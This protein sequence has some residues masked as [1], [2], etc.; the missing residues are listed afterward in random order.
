MQGH[1]GSSAVGHCTG[2]TSCM[3][4]VSQQV[5]SSQ[6][7]SSSTEVV[8]S[9]ANSPKILYMGQQTSM[10][11]CRLVRGVL[12]ELEEGRGSHHS[13]GPPESSALH[14]GAMPARSSPATTPSH[15]ASSYC[16]LETLNMQ[17]DAAPDVLSVACQYSPALAYVA[18]FVSPSLSSPQPHAVCPAASERHAPAWWQPFLH[19]RL[20]ATVS[21]SRIEGLPSHHSTLPPPAAQRHH[22]HC[23]APNTAS[24]AYRMDR[25]PGKAC[26]APLQQQP[27]PAQAQPSLPRLPGAACRQLLLLPHCQQPCLLPCLPTVRCTFCQ[28][29]CQHSASDST[30]LCQ[31]LDRCNSVIQSSCWLP[32]FSSRA[33]CHASQ[34][35]AAVLRAGSITPKVFWS[36]F[37]GLTDS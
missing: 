19:T 9:S 16:L 14:G 22:K 27:S 12:D 5:F 20:Q 6:R 29:L 24:V 33:S 18:V 13:R 23:T 37:V 2:L 10:L 4:V 17:D 31:A 30:D 3:A 32:I 34:R 26:P 36:V 7:P 35:C 11:T 1:C 28:A 21:S 8:T 15:Q 25:Q